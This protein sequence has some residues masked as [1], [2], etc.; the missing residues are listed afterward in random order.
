MAHIKGYPFAQE[1]LMDKP[2]PVMTLGINRDNSANSRYISHID[3]HAIAGHATRVIASLYRDHFYL[4][5]KDCLYVSL[6]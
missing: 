1:Q 5:H 3:R 6:P 4:P 2:H